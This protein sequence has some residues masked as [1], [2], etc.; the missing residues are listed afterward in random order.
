[1]FAPHAHPDDSDA[2]STLDSSEVASASDPGPLTETAA[3][4]S[5]DLPCRA[6]Y[7]LTHPRG[8]H[9]PH[10]EAL[11]SGEFPAKC[12][13]IEWG[14]VD[15]M[16]PWL[17]A[18]STDS[19][20]LSRRMVHMSILGVHSFPVGPPRSHFATAL[21]SCTGAFTMTWMTI[22]ACMRTVGVARMWT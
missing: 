17:R 20:L 2:T 9:V 11:S 3:R 13:V 22:S 16:G 6:F 5:A 1:M 8:G 15:E 10:D 14:G 7:A 12:E 19:L 21:T 4:G 18:R